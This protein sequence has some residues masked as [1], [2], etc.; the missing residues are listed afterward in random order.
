MLLCNTQPCGALAVIKLLPHEWGADGWPNGGGP[1]PHCLQGQWPAPLDHPAHPGHREEL[2][3]QVLPLG[4]DLAHPKGQGHHHTF[5]G[6][7]G[8]GLQ[9]MC[10]VRASQTHTSYSFCVQCHVQARAG[11]MDMS[12]RKAIAIGEWAL[13]NEN[14]GWPWVGP[15]AAWGMR[16]STS[17]S[18]ACSSSSITF[19]L[20]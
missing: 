7:Q 3:G 16:A 5:E 17:C 2:H 4:A 11:G 8:V 6:V 12:R 1:G 13:L 10:A 20:S 15:Q 14:S 9:R 18:R 19:N